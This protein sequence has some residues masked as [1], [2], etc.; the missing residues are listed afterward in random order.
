MTLSSIAVKSFQLSALASALVLVGCG[1]GHNDTVQPGLTTGGVT[2]GTTTPA[3]S[4][5]TTPTTSDVNISAINL[6]DSTGQSVTTI[7]GSGAT[8]TVK[9]TDATGKGISGAIVTFSASGGVTFGTTNSSVLTNAEGIA[10]TSVKPTNT[11][12]TGA[13]TISAS[14]SYNGKTAAT[15]NAYAFSLQPANIVLSNVAAANTSLASGGSTNITLL[16]QDATT[17]AAQNNVAVNFTTSCGTFSSP[18]VTSSNQGNVTT[19]YQAIDASGKLCEGEQTI[20]ASTAGGSTP[21]QTIKLSIAA[22]QASSIVYTSTQAVSLATRNSGSSS[23]GQVEFTVYANGIPAANQKVIVSKSYSPSDFSFGTLGNQAPLTMTSDSNGKVIVTLYPGAL[24][25]PVELK[26]SLANDPNI[27]ALSKNVTI[28]NSRATQNGITAGIGKNV[29]LN[30]TDDSTSITM[31][32]TNRNG[33]NV[34]VG[35]VV[36]FVAEGGRISPSCATDEN[37][38]CTVTFT[39]QQPRPLN[40][41][42]T[43]LAYLEGDKQYIDKDGDNSYT[44][45]V[46]SL[47]RNIGDFFRDDNENNVYNS[48]IGEFIYRRNAGSLACNNAGS[49]FEPNIEGTCSNELA[50]TLRRQF[51]FG[52]ADDTPTFS[53][54]IRLD[55]NQT[56]QIY[57]NSL[58]TVSMPSGTTIAISAEDKTDNKVDCTPKLVHM[59]STDTSFTVPA[60]VALGTVNDSTNTLINS[61]QVTYS[62]LLNGCDTG[63]GK[64]TIRLTITAPNGHITKYE[65]N[66]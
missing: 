54:P 35:T 42:A 20:T 3:S 50:T 36:N 24:P 27:S 23:S 31:R 16:T 44:A 53:T 45:G 28:V 17:K 40:G 66:G 33:T 25:G 43:V 4:T 5:G 58:Q 30:N 32:F 1:G 7:N 10:S 19:T 57:G 38:S 55:T 61:P 51:V 37:G 48:D 34:P 18:S 52:F 29:L 59:G 65:I 8:A 41:R 47:V 39:S 12:D 2:G 49:F 22:I 63:L 62:S 6:T 15:S 56:F 14:A 46:D 60:I 9:V 11:T 64:D 13:Y 26:A 21:P